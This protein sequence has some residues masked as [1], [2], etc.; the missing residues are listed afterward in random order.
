M[1]DQDQ[2][3]LDNQNQPDQELET[4][5]RQAEEYLNNWKRERA[6]FVNYKKDEAK[7]VE[8]IVKFGNE[9][10][11]LEL[12]E[13]ID[14]FDI[15]RK[16]FPQYQGSK[17]KDWLDAFDKTISKFQEFLNKY[18]V[19]KIKIGDKFDPVLYEAVEVE[20]EGKKI[21]EVRAGY[22][23]HGKVIRPARVRIIN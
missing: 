19:E 2:D 1:N 7:R 14:E 15:V 4:A 21:E 22:I 6:D 8:E 23:M 16:N 17:V 3:Q 9:S 18:E 12:I 20:P 13:I 10:I 5:K 11:V